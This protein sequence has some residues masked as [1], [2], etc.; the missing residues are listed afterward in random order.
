MKNL[1]L[2]LCCVFLFQNSN[3]QDL[4]KS[5]GDFVISTK[6]DFNGV[7]LRFDWL[8][9]NMSVKISDDGY[10]FTIG[11]DDLSIQYKADMSDATFKLQK[12]IVGEKYVDKKIEKEQ[13]EKGVPIKG[14]D[15]EAIK[16]LVH[17][18]VALVSTTY[19]VNK[20]Y[21]AGFKDDS[22]ANGIGIELYGKGN[23]YA[24]TFENGERNG[25]GSYI[26]GGEQILN[27]HFKKGVQHGNFKVQDVSGMNAEGRFENGKTEGRWKYTYAN[28]TKEEKFFKNGQEVEQK[29][30]AAK[31]LA[32]SLPL[33]ENMNS[34]FVEELK[35]GK[36]QSTS[37]S[38]AFWLSK[39]PEGYRFNF[40]NKGYGWKSYTS[41]LVD[42]Q[43]SAG[44]TVETYKYNYKEGGGASSPRLTI[45]DSRQ[46]KNNKAYNIVLHLATEDFEQK[47][48]F[49]HDDASAE[50]KEAINKKAKENAAKI[51]AEMYKATAAEAK[52]IIAAAPT[53]F[54]GLWKPGKY[55]YGKTVSKLPYFEE[56]GVV[57]DA[58][59][60][61]T[62]NI[63]FTKD[64]WVSFIGDEVP[65]LVAALDEALSPRFEKCL[66]KECTT[67]SRPKNFPLFST[68]TRAPNEV[69]IWKQKGD[70]NLK[71]GKYGTVLLYYNYEDQNVELSFHALYE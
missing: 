71:T 33:K 59:K 26:I 5:W 65:K 44:K 40:K 60:H 42:V 14:R 66:N 57:D 50:E 23:A 54:K 58:P 12:I 43:K 1:V 31:S 19:K 46:S 22:Y 68:Q 3:A 28:G 55:H 20:E 63:V 67:A 37:L 45:F 36:A 32:S 6:V 39:H 35:N 52:K 7:A 69:Y 64:T 18:F 56:A 53:Q 34:Q 17:D 61:G 15:T 21:G 4:P 41:Q 27:G 29:A 62:I 51:M 11:G 49:L 24:G 13:R 25:P 9:E 48:Y 47:F 10:H 30:T 70:A 16:N 2:S 38:K 8:R